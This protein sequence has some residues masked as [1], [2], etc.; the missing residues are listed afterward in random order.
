MLEAKKTVLAPQGMDEAH[1]RVSVFVWITSEKLS[2]SFSK[3]V[4][5]FKS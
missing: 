3:K 4:Q 1:R 2:D 5:Q